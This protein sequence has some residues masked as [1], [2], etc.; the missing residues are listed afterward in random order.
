MLKSYRLPL[1]FA[2]ERLRSDVSGLWPEDWSPHF[3]RS[4]F[5]GEW[6]GVALRS[7]GGRAGQL[8]P[9][10]TAQGS[11]A[12]TPFLARCPNIREVLRAFECPLESVRLLKLAAGSRIREHRDHELGPEN[13]TIRVHIPVVTSPLVEFYLDNRRIQMREG[14]TWYLNFNL[15]HRIYNGSEIDRVHLVIDCLVNDWLRSMIPF[16]DAA[17]GEHEITVATEGFECE[18]P[19]ARPGLEE[20]RR[21]VLGD[22]A[23]QMSLRETPNLK[24][25]LELMPELGRAHGCVFNQAD[26]EEALRASRRAWF[27]TW[28]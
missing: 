26:V 13:G 23:L 11:F 3:N 14:E 27:E 19:R 16:D 12:D 8:Y 24:A 1:N 7:V 4:Y 10:P 5:E 18:S 20:F 6:S 21:I 28:I 9:D 22:A 2:P 17:R 15:P 25:F